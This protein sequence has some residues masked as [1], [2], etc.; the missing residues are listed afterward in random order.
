MALDDV[1]F[2]TKTPHVVSGAALFPIMNAIDRIAL[3]LRT[4]LDPP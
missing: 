2:D 4:H 3:H 1:G